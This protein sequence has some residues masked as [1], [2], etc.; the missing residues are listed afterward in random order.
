MHMLALNKIGNQCT[1]WYTEDR[2]LVQA[3]SLYIWRDPPC[4]TEILVYMYTKKK[5][6]Y[7]ND[8]RM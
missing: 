7:L 5:L 6:C 1:Q 2:R 3:F 8:S 4:S